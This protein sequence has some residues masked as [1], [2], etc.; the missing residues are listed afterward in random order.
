MKSRG[1]YETPGGTLLYTAHSELEQLTLDRRTL[2]A[3]DQVATRYAELVYEGRW[4]T[5][6]R[7]AYDA[8]VEVTQRN[9]TGTITLSLYKGSVAVAGRTS[10]CPLYDERFVTFGADDVYHQ[11]DAAGFIRLF[12]LSHRVAALKARERADAAAHAAAAV[13]GAN[14]AAAP[15]QANDASVPPEETAPTD[16]GEPVEVA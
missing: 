3:K 12:G 4:W 7:E 9:V 8:L 11:A 6:E 10:P 16:V 2:A 5:T 13:N 14:G 15:A 1:V